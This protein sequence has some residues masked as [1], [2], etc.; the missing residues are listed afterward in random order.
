MNQSI[1]SRI[2]EK[3]KIK[4][5]VWLESRDHVVIEMIFNPLRNNTLL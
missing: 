3:R 2:I 5:H 4:E 1:K